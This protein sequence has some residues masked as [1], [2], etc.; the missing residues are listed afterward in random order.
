MLAQPSAQC[1]LRQAR[2]L[3]S[4]QTEWM[5]GQG[6]ND[7]CEGRIPAEVADED[8]LIFGGEITVRLERELLHSQLYRWIV[9]QQLQVLGDSACEQVRLQD[10]VEAFAREHLLGFDQFEG[11]NLEFGLDAAIQGAG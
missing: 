2:E 8:A 4:H 6:A 11:G 3:F 9:A 7:G 10:F 5:S 1:D